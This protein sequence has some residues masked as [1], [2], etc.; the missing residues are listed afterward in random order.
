MHVCNLRVRFCRVSHVFLDFTFKLAI[1]Q[2]L[3]R[4]PESFGER[5]HFVHA[6]AIAREFSRI[7][8][9]KH[10]NVERCQLATLQNPVSPSVT[11]AQTATIQ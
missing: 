5:V 6:M 4:F 7:F 2:P 8:S 10:G 3:L 1:F 11:K 9:R